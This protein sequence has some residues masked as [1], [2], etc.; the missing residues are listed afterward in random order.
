MFIQIVRQLY[1]SAYFRL[2]FWVILIGLMLYLA[3]RD[4]NLADVWQTLRQADLRFIWL[5]LLSVVINI[6]SKTMRWQVLISSPGKDIG[7]GKI[8]MALLG[9]QTL[10]WFLPG[11]VGEL[12]RLYVVGGMGPGR[13]Y[14]LGTIAIE[15]VL[16][17]LAYALL[18]LLL[19]LI[20]PLPN[21][22]NNSGVTFSILTGLVTLVFIFV[23]LN[24]R[25]IGEIFEKFTRWMPERFRAPLVQRVQSGLESLMVIR[26]RSDLLKLAA[27][28]LLTWGSA[29]WTNSLVAQALGL[30]LP[31]TAAGIVLIVLQAGIS[32]P[33]VPGRIGLFQY[34]CILALALFA[35]NQVNGL[36][37]GILLQAVIFIPPTLFGLFSLW[38]LGWGNTQG[39][40]TGSGE[41]IQG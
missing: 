27:L 9:G 11:R 32:V 26:R 28:T 30:R 2:A 36:G 37:F 16:D 39:I 18:F 4:V 20:L 25:W 15:K 19:L 10:N 21:W 1:R 41:K 5:A 38:F 3:L 14:I 12:Y 23:A 24:P 13:T 7:F 35:V 17:M 22:I 6:W 8:S 33:S 31:W 40:L 34:L 29:V